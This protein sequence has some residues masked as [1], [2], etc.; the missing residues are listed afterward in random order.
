MSFAA[1]IRV[2]AVNR[3]VFPSGFGRL[4]WRVECKQWVGKSVAWFA[5]SACFVI[6][7]GILVGFSL[8]AAQLIVRWDDNSYDEDGFE[9]E[10]T[11]DGNNFVLM[12]RVPANFTSFVDTT[13]APA[14][15]YWYR[16]KAYNAASRG[17]DSNVAGAATPLNAETSA[18]THWRRIGMTKSKLMNLSARAVPG[19]DER[20]L[21]VG[22]VVREGSKSVM[23]RAVGPGI[24]QYL[25]AATLS[26]PTLTV[27]QGGKSILENNDWGGT[28]RLKQAFN[29]VGAFPLADGS[30]DAVL[31]SD[32]ASAAYTVGVQGNGAGFAMAEIYDAD[33][34]SGDARRL[35]NVSVRAPAGVGDDVLIVGFVISGGTPMRVLVRASGPALYDLGVRSALTDP[36]V[37]LYRGNVKW[38]HNDNWS[39]ERI[40]ADA[41]AEAGAFD[42]GSAGSRDAALVITLPPGAYTAVVS[43]VS[44]TTGVALAEVYELP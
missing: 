23:L 27:N 12:G 6:L 25:S 31:L 10:R 21:I 35:A 13:V 17:A 33:A 40:L 24:A 11:Q 41:S 5:R 32:F 19:M 7:A 39:G 20:S 3:D 4:Q 42:W 37:T 22:F 8:S 38:S 36:Q 34:M 9:V 1:D 26:D 44:G 43:G 30:K 14:T 29:Q 2:R 28:D 18:E 16:V 15:S